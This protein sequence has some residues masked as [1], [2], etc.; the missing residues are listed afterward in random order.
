M[1]LSQL[2]K[3]IK[4]L[5]LERFKLEMEMINSLSRKSMLPGSVV[6][7][8]IICG[9]E[10]CKC[11]KGSLHGPFYYLTY[12]ENKKTKMIFLKTAIS[13][14]AKVLNDSYKSFRK[15]RA[16][17]SM[18]NRQILALMDEIEKINTVSLSGIKED[19]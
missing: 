18:I 3:K 12:K 7:K 11:K 6:E 19:G 9:K 10:G 16:K 8:Y 1:D 17:V 5:N 13:K 4:D 2:R 14:R 15:L